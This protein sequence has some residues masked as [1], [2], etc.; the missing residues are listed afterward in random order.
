M[1]QSVQPRRKTGGRPKTG[2]EAIE[3][4][5]RHCEWLDRRLEG[6]TYQEIADEYGVTKNAVYSAVVALMTEMPAE[7]AESLRKME[8]ARLDRQFRRLE[9]QAKVFAEGDEPNPQVEAVLLKNSERRCKLLGL[10]LPVTKAANDEQTVDIE[11]LRKL[12]NAVGFEV[13]PMTQVVEAK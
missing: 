13:V 9:R 11:E 3:V 10:D 4:R 6:C 12:L 1:D 7:D 5:K 8:L 2:P